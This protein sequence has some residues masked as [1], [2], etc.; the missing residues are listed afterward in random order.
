MEQIQQ[1]K[2]RE[3]RQ[4]LEQREQRYNLRNWNNKISKCKIVQFRINRIRDYP[5][6]SDWNEIIVPQTN[7]VCKIEAESKLIDEYEIESF[8]LNIFGKGARVLAIEEEDEEILMYRTIRKWN[9]SNKL[10]RSNKF[11]IPKSRSIIVSNE[12]IIYQKSNWNVTNIKRENH[13]NL[14]VPRKKRSLSQQENQKI[15]IFANKKRWNLSNRAQ[16]IAKLIVVGEKR[17]WELDIASGDEVFIN[18]EHSEDEIVNYNDHNRVDE[19]KLQRTVRATIRQVHHEYDSDE[20]EEDIDPLG[21]IQKHQKS[22]KYSK[23]FQSTYNKKVK[24]TDD[25]KIE[26]MEYERLSEDT[27]HR[28]ISGRKVIIEKHEQ[29]PKKNIINVPRIERVIKVD[30]FQSQREKIIV[31]PRKKTDFGLGKSQVIQ[32]PTTE[33]KQEE[34]VPSSSQVISHRVINI[35]KD[36]NKGEQT[37]KKKE[38]IRRTDE[39]NNNQYK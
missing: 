15:S 19:A 23:Y 37:K 11:T 20:V 39:V 31:L 2:H 5:I 12:K 3:Q 16:K 4:Q 34:R 27:K 36:V 26:K 30:D 7:F 1:R 9:Q 35:P 33:I 28:D 10:I 38:Y 24:K 8:S 13:F 21:N 22:S 14:I 29:L 32:K 6:G 18:R 17:P 25:M